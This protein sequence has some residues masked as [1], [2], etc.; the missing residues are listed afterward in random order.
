RFLREV[1]AAAMLS[2]PNV[3]Q[4]HDAGEAGGAYFL[5]MQLLRGMDLARYLKQRG[6]LPVAEPVD[7]G[8]QACEGM[9]RAHE[10]GVVDR[11]LKPANLWLTQKRQVKILDLGL[12][13]VVEATTLTLAG[14]AFGTVDYMAPEQV[15]DSHKVDVR[16]DVYSLGCTLYHLLAGTTP[17]S[18]T[19]PA[20]RPAM[21]LSHE[22]PPV[23]QRRPDLHPAAPDLVPPLMAN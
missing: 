4:V 13:L 21:H 11:A 2:H 12:A 3:V 5:T 15:T 17:F 22:P 6:P 23:E 20:A 8:R 16:A 19:H 10:T 14:G 9:Q 18:D 1:R 7:Y